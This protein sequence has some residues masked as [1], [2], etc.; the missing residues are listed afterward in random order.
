MASEAEVSIAASNVGPVLVKSFRGSCRSLQWRG[1]RG[2]SRDD[3]SGRAVLLLALQCLS[4]FFQCLSWF[5]SVR[6]GLT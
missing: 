6:V 4:L 1:L 2:M 3:L 5:C